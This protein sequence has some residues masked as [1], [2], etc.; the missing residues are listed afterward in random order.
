LIL[1]NEFVPEALR[2]REFASAESPERAALQREQLGRARRMLE[3]VRGEYES[4]PYR[5]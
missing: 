3:R 2:R 5:A 1:L 4:F